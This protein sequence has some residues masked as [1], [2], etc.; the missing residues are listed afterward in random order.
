VNTPAA[1][2]TTAV[3]CRSCRSVL[4]VVDEQ[5]LTIK[6]GGLEVVV[7]GDFHASFICYRCRTLNVFRPAVRADASRGIER[8]S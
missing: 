1:R 7:D 5:G 8:T 4:A 6:R 2:P 3:R